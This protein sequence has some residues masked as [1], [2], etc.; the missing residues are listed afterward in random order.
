MPDFRFIKQDEHEGQ[1]TVETNYQ[2]KERNSQK[3]K[4]WF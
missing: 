1:D 4:S 2:Q 3:N